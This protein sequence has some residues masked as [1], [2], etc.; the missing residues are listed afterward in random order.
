MYRLEREAPEAKRKRL[1]QSDS[2]GSDEDEKEDLEF[3]DANGK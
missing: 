2:E 1:L 3:L